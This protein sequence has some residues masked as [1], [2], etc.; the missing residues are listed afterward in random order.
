MDTA[1]RPLWGKLVRDLRPEVQRRFDELTLQGYTAQWLRGTKR[2]S[3]A[4]PSKISLDKLQAQDA[5]LYS[6]VMEPSTVID[7]AAVE[8]D[9]FTLIISTQYDYNFVERGANV[10][11]RLAQLNITNMQ[12]YLWL[13]YN[14]ESEAGAAAVLAALAQFRQSIPADAELRRQQLATL[15]SSV[16]ADTQLRTALALRFLYRLAPNATLEELRAASTDHLEPVARASSIETLDSVFDQF[17]QEESTLG[18]LTRVWVHSRFGTAETQAFRVLSTQDSVL[19]VSVER[20]CTYIAYQRGVPL[21]RDRA[22]AALPEAQLSLRAVFR[23]QL[24]TQLPSISQ[25]ARWSE[26]DQDWLPLVL[27]EPAYEYVYPES[28]VQRQQGKLYTWKQLSSTSLSAVKEIRTVAAREELRIPGET[29]LLAYAHQN[30]V[31]LP[32]HRPVLGGE[33]IEILFTP[34]THWLR[35]AVATRLDDI[36]VSPGRSVLV[37]FSQ[38][39]DGREVVEDWSRSTATGVVQLED[40]RKPRRQL[41][42]NSIAGVYSV[43]FQGAKFSVSVDVR[44]YCVRCDAFYSE[45]ENRDG[46]CQWHTRHVEE[47]VRRLDS[48]RS[49][50]DVVQRDAEAIR[51]QLL[52]DPVQ[53]NGHAALL[54]SPSTE[55]LLSQLPLTLLLKA[56]L[57][58]PNY[59]QFAALVL[60][61]LDRLEAYLRRVEYV[62]FSSR[63]AN[64]WH[65]EGQFSVSKF[66]AHMSVRDAQAIPQHD[67][68]ERLFLRGLLSSLQFEDYSLRIFDP[69]QDGAALLAGTEQRNPNI[70]FGLISQGSQ[71]QWACC[72]RLPGH[73]GCWSGRHSFT[74]TL[75]DLEDASVQSR[76]SRWL[77]ASYEPALEGL[78]REAQLN[79]PLGGV[80]RPTLSL[81]RRGQAI[82]DLILSSEQPLPQLY[83]GEK[84]PENLALRQLLLETKFDPTPIGLWKHDFSTQLLYRPNSSRPAEYSAQYL[85]R[86]LRVQKLFRKLKTQTAEKRKA[87]LDSLLQRKLGIPLPRPVPR[88]VELQYENL[89][90]TYTEVSTEYDELITFINT[91]RKNFSD[92]F[93][94]TLF[95]KD[96]DE[97]LGQLKIETANVSAKLQEHSSF[98]KV[99]PGNDT[100]RKWIDDVKA[101]VTEKVG[102]L[103]EIS[104]DIRQIKI[105]FETDSSLVKARANQ[106]VNDTNI[107]KNLNSIYFKQL[108]QHD[109]KLKDAVVKRTILQTKILTLLKIE[110][111]KPFQE[112][113]QSILKSTEN[114]DFTIPLFAVDADSWQDLV[115]QN[116]ANSKKLVDSQNAYTQNM[117]Y[118]ETLKNGFKGKNLDFNRSIF[119]AAIG[120]PGTHKIN[121]KQFQNKIFNYFGDEETWKIVNTTVNDV[122]QNTLRL[123]SLED[124]GL[125]ANGTP[126]IPFK[127]KNKILPITPEVTRLINNLNFDNDNYIAVVQPLEKISDVGFSD[128]MS[129]FLLRLNLIQDPE[130]ADNLYDT[131]QSVAIAMAQKPA[132]MDYIR[133]KWGIQQPLD[134]VASELKKLFGDNK[135]DAWEFVVRLLTKALNDADLD[136]ISA[137]DEPADAERRRQAEEEARLEEEKTAL[138]QKKEETL[139]RIEEE[140]QE[141]QRKIREKE[142]AESEQKEREAEEQARKAAEE[143]EKKQNEANGQES[144]EKKSLEDE[145]NLKEIQRRKQ[146]RERMLAEVRKLTEK[147]SELSRRELE[148]RTSFFRMS[149]EVLRYK[150]EVSIVGQISELGLLK[151]TLEEGNQDDERVKSAIK[152]INEYLEIQKKLNDYYSDEKS[153]PEEQFDQKTLNTQDELLRENIDK[154]IREYDNA[155]YRFGGLVVDIVSKE[156]REKTE[157]D[158]RVEAQEEV[159]NL[160]TDAN[161]FFEVV[162]NDKIRELLRDIVPEAFL[163]ELLKITQELP[164]EPTEETSEEVDVGTV[165]EPLDRPTASNYKDAL[166]QLAYAYKIGKAF[167]TKPIDKLRGNY[168]KLVTRFQRDAQRELD[169]VVAYAKRTDRYD[170]LSRYTYYAVMLRNLAEKYSPAQWFDQLIDEVYE[171]ES[172]RYQSFVRE[173]TAEEWA[174]IQRSY[175]V[176]PAAKPAPSKGTKPAPSK[177][178]PKA[179]PPELPDL[180]E[181]ST[182]QLNKLATKYAARIRG[183]KESEYPDGNVF[184]YTDVNDDGEETERMIGV[185][186]E[187]ADLLK[188]YTLSTLFNRTREE[189]GEFNLANTRDILAFGPKKDL[190]TDDQPKI[191]WPQLGI[192]VGASK[193]IKFAWLQKR[194]IAYFN[195]FLAMYN[196]PLEEPA[197]EE[198]EPQQ[199]KKRATAKP[200]GAKAKA[201]VPEATPKTTPA[202]SKSPELQKLPAQKAKLSDNTY[203]RDQLQNLYNILDRIRI[204]NDYVEESGRPSNQYYEIQSLLL[205]KDKDSGFLTKPVDIID[206]SGDFD[207]RKD[208]DYTDVYWILD[209]EQYFPD[210]D[211]GNPPEEDEFQQFLLNNEFI[212]IMDPNYKKFYRDAVRRIIKH[213]V[214]IYGVT[215]SPTSTSYDNPAFLFLD[216][217]PEVP[218]KD[219]VPAKDS[220]KATAKAKSAV[221][222]STPAPTKGK[223]GATQAVPKSEKPKAPESDIIENFPNLENVRIGRQGSVKAQQ[224]LVIQG[225]TK[226][227]KENNNNL[228]SAL[229]QYLTPDESDE[230]DESKEEEDTELIVLTEIWMV[231]GGKTHTALDSSNL[232]V[233]SLKANDEIRRLAVKYRKDIKNTQDQKELLIILLKQLFEKWVL[234]QDATKIDFC[235]GPELQQ[236]V[237]LSDLRKALDI[238]AYMRPEQKQI[239]NLNENI[240]LAQIYEQLGDLVMG[241]STDNAFYTE[242]LYRNL[243][244]APAIVEDLH[245]IEKERLNG[246]AATFEIKT[247]FYKTVLIQK[248]TLEKSFGDILDVRKQ[249]SSEQ[250]VKK[251]LAK[252]KA[253]PTT[254]VPPLI[255]LPRTDADA[256]FAAERIAEAEAA[257]GFQILSTRWPSNELSQLRENLRVT[258]GKIGRIGFRRDIVKESDWWNI[259][260]VWNP[261]YAEQMWEQYIG[262]QRN[263]EN[264]MPELGFY[265]ENY[266]EDLTRENLKTLENQ[267]F[268]D[269]DA[270]TAKAGR[271][272]EIK[273]NYE[274]IPIPIKMP[275]SNDYFDDGYFNNTVEEEKRR[276]NEAYR[277][278][279]KITTPDTTLIRNTADIREELLKPYGKRLLYDISKVILSKV[280]IGLAK[281]GYLMD[282]NAASRSVP[283]ILSND[284]SRDMHL[285]AVVQDNQIIAYAVVEF[286]DSSIS[287]KEISSQSLL[288]SS[289]LLT[290]I[291]LDANVLDSIQTM[292]LQPSRSIV[293]K[294]IDGQMGKLYNPV[295]FDDAYLATVCGLTSNFPAQHDNTTAIPAGVFDRTTAYIFGQTKKYI[296]LYTFPKDALER[297]LGKYDDWL[298]SE[299]LD[300]L[301]VQNTATVE[302]ILSRGLKVNGY[303][304]LPKYQAQSSDPV[305]VTLSFPSTPK[306]EL[307]AKRPKSEAVDSEPYASPQFSGKLDHGRAAAFLSTQIPSKSLMNVQQELPSRIQTVLNFMNNLAGI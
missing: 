61:R 106:F 98:E 293:Y 238:F 221:P 192:S 185:V 166:L 237:E 304:A 165:I 214:N 23:A 105:D 103:S 230:S 246:S 10:T 124:L 26:K 234:K 274:K 226:L 129:E 128:L 300:A 216:F 148:E 62:N 59:R 45:L 305:M 186:Y 199:P 189:A 16:T 249:L 207:L 264:E 65:S 60:S 241:A 196:L 296:D 84:K 82:L 40:Y 25:P 259:A 57:R 53:L 93:G 290:Q 150:L 55:V 271:Y 301:Q 87:E 24:V 133:Q 76:A 47:I 268:K 78:Q 251:I 92:T 118:F 95:K 160:L 152:D 263:E 277:S 289:S 204:E 209:I 140:K 194:M 96:L 38:M 243:Q 270:K 235:I 213:M 5:G 81:S 169:I 197:A 180:T 88:A 41:S 97:F 56:L 50:E 229:E 79:L 139:R 198:P 286:S 37:D 130:G 256:W 257:G 116:I 161:D 225:W 295:R 31:F 182:D 22:N 239:R 227:L 131:T 149:N 77:D 119:K 141:A 287:I 154:I 69:K 67:P 187:F 30:V 15:F 109:E 212:Y 104:E 142:R 278:A 120:D 190:V 307:T 163:N 113:L 253:A 35:A 18:Y 132:I 157:E 83:Y 126:L 108:K 244:S 153:V 122:A 52:S 168:D 48:G 177:G 284:E 28:R 306:L 193:E 188:T 288:H 297:N 68:A 112:F 276:L 39:T 111:M 64:L 171:E 210:T 33:D 80:L 43:V 70:H 6:L 99:D 72:G 146:E 34:V 147:Q 299:I 262:S 291:V 117:E 294:K 27:P 247:P 222:K 4:D 181:L 232:D 261:K 63:G 71:R 267:I 183:L 100:D 94:N 91:E 275:A 46:A 223:G 195:E 172:E 164:K 273:K 75:P 86:A 303:Q 206:L 258:T 219:A 21:Y 158:E 29:K 14:G 245:A 137:F 254:P 260:N 1:V 36:V 9:R 167:E 248:Q 236:P 174:D 283:N 134:V 2:I 49:I 107:A 3:T 74:T 144:R 266:S 201:A 85:E 54:K 155:V 269:S 13:Q 121:L 101:F 215:I 242:E 156:T 115:K 44:G 32:E 51:Q 231:L 114:A 179:G 162:R 159:K 145:G 302:P 240:V 58:M 7:R 73:P 138:K 191:E 184:R 250:E 281:Q 292:V 205:S 280:A 135:K 125:R 272:I 217:Y 285:Y 170:E 110:E 228:R 173:P 279:F 220:T 123:S 127:F 66:I 42:G 102:K 218:K 136:T 203:S 211:A 202:P 265:F 90:K 12:S 17:L 200:K 208:F 143:Q 176:E 11:Y 252:R 20:S 282:A 8:I 19:R 224:R 178:A 175:G 151:R 89:G 255:T 233:E 298:K